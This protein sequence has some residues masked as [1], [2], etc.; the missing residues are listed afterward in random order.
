MLLTNTI[1]FYD[2][3]GVYVVVGRAVNV[4]YL[5]FCKAFDTAKSTLER[6]TRQGDCGKLAGCSG[7]KDS[8]QWFKV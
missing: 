4:I 6:W 1:T 8:A 5:E 3:I 2:E 7:S